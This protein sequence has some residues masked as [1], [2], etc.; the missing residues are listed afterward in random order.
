MINSEFELK[1]VNKP[2]GFEFEL[3]DNKSISIWCVSIGQEHKSGYLLDQCS[4]SFHMHTSKTAKVF[5][6]EGA[7]EL[8][9]ND[10]SFILN[11]SI[12]YVLPPRTPHKLSAHHG[13]AILL[14][15]ELP[16]NRSDII[17]LKDSYGRSKNLYSWDVIDSKTV[18]SWKSE[19]R[20]KETPYDINI[21]GDNL[22][23]CMYLSNGV[24]VEY[25]DTNITQY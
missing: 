8:F 11:E 14:E 19:L 12:P 20:N 24:A 23:P 5:V 1:L 7:I 4:T 13:N 25:L 18:K 16:S 22:S 21:T 6:L 2:W 10:G 3:L 9:Q 17:R 15:V